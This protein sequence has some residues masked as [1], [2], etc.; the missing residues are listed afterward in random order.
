[1]LFTQNIA[2]DGN[3]NN[4]VYNLILW[5]FSVQLSFPL[6]CSSAAP[7]ARCARRPQIVFIAKNRFVFR[8][9]GS[10]GSITG[11]TFDEEEE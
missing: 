8:L 6:Y 2:A 9:R 3:S 5:T 11:A 10:S 1:M 4:F 7:V